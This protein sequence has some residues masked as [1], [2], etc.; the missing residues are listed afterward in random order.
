MVF[1]NM[2]FRGM[3]LGYLRT[4]PLHS[5]VFGVTATA[6]MP[7]HSAENARWIGVPVDREMVVPGASPGTV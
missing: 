3:K 7:R 5:M 1:G 4:T 2:D 6:V